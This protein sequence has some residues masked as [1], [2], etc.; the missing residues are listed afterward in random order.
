M[1]G[2]GY[3]FDGHGNPTDDLTP[4]STFV[5]EL[6]FKDLNPNVAYVARPCQF[7]KTELC[8]QKAWSTGRFSQEAVQALY[9]ASKAMAGGTVKDLDKILAWNLQGIECEL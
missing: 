4:K 2:D 1:E 5:W 6:A 7:V 3:G 9:E 8:T